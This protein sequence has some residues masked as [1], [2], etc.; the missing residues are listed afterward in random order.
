MGARKAS[1]PHKAVASA[2]SGRRS[3]ALFWAGAGAVIVALLAVVIIAA[4][5]KSPDRREEVSTPAELGN[6]PA[7][8]AVG[9]DVAPPWPAPADAA[10]AV[11]AAG[12]PM[13]AEEGV[14][15]HIH[16]HL[17]VFVDG[18]RVQVPSDIGIDRNRGG[19]SPLHTHDTSG[20]IHIESPVKR[21]FSLGE[22]FTEWDV[23]LSA[24]NVGALRVGNGKTVRVYV[25]GDLRTGNPAAITFGPHDEV[26]LLYGTPNPGETVPDSYEF[27]AG[28]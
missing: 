18:Q 23:S 14:V 22:F 13:L 2:R 24:D 10:A 8:V 11:S 1:K 5:T 3:G 28:E 16:S 19:I 20:V 4:I 6:A 21:A 9:G 27:P 17:D 12:L 26:A 25:N 7:T 15:E